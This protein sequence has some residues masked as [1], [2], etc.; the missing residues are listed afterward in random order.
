MIK[1]L[2]WFRV[3]NLLKEVALKEVAYQNGKGNTWYKKTSLINVSEGL[4]HVTCAKAMTSFMSSVL[5]LWKLVELHPRTAFSLF[6]FLLPPCPPPPD[7][8]PKHSNNGVKAKKQHLKLGMN[9]WPL[10]INFV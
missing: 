7:Y 3:D 5:Q 6:F 10:Y 9:L 4:L 1:C 8:S 2:K